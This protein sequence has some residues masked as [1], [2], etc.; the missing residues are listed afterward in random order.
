M[1]L[2]HEFAARRGLPA[3]E[4]VPKGLLKAYNERQKSHAGA[5]AANTG[6]AE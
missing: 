5:A 3:D 4:F 6:G 2:K 1:R